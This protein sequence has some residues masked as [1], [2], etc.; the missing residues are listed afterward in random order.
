MVGPRTS[1]VPADH[2]YGEGI[3]RALVAVLGVTTVSGA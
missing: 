2:G 1:E 3:F